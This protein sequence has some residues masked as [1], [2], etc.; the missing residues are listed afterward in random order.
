MYSPFSLLREGNPVPLCNSVSRL[1]FIFQNT[2]LFIIVLAEAM[3]CLL[4]VIKTRMICIFLH[5]SKARESICVAIPFSARLSL[6]CTRCGRR[7]FP[8]SYSDGGG[9]PAFRPACHFHRQQEMSWRE[10]GHLSSLPRRNCQERPHTTLQRCGNPP[11][12]LFAMSF[13]AVSCIML[14]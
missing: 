3:F 7:I 4:Q 10:Q 9:G 5:S 2:A 1:D 13:P 12:F 8:G 14:I 6:H 11:F